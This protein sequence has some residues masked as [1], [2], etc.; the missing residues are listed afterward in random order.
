MAHMPSMYYV[1]F[2]LVMIAIANAAPVDFPNIQFLGSGYD[3]I[4][5]DPHATSQTDPGFRQF[6]FNLTIYNGQTTPDHLYYLPLGV[7][8]TKSISCALNFQAETIGSA[9]GYQQLL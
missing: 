9:Y 6:V 2:L 5:G 4:L 1:T 7:E 3:L 8:A